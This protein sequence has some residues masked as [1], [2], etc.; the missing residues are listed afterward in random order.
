MSLGVKAQPMSAFTNFQNQFMT[1]D[2]GIIRKADFLIPISYDIGRIAVPY[3]DNS[4][5]FKVFYNGATQQINT[6][7]TT[8]YQ[9]TDNLITYKNGNALFVWEAGKTMMLSSNAPISATGDSVVLYFDNMRSLY[10][11]YYKGEIYEIEQ[12]LGTNKNIFDT[13]KVND[14]MSIAEGQLSSIRVSDNIAAYV[15]FANKFKIFYHGNIINQEDF[16]IN[17]FDVGR[18][19]VPYVDAN[20]E[21]NVFFNGEKEKLESLSP[22]SYKAG[23]NLVAYV[24]NDNYFKVFYNGKVHE[25]GYFEPTYTVKDNVV[26]FY[27]NGGYFKVFYKGNVYNLDPTNPKT[28]KAGYN[29][30]AFVN[31][32]NVLKLF[33]DGKIYDVINGDVAEWRL[34]YDVIQYRFGQ[35]MYKVFYNGKSY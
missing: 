21:F 7:F 13:T 2:N 32:A 35:N 31:N 24:S 17:S 28:I 34:D 22:I 29:S 4:R 11:A 6:G 25:I 26:M 12:F 15:N 16:L 30:V 20:Y 3:I 5:N 1:W 14:G 33:S 27:D 8:G 23:D 10:N 9:V 18:N 19:I